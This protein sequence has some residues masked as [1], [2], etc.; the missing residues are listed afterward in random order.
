MHLIGGSFFNRPANLIPEKIL[1]GNSFGLFSPRRHAPRQIFDLI[2]GFSQIAL[3]FNDLQDFRWFRGYLLIPEKGWFKKGFW[4]LIFLKSLVESDSWNSS[5]SVFSEMIFQTDTRAELTM[6]WIFKQTRWAQLPAPHE[7]HFFEIN[8]EYFWRYWKPYK[9]Q[10]LF[11]NYW[12]SFE[13]SK[14]LIKPTFS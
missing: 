9:S 7:I 14:T 13:T 4:F 10:R 5:E 2:I 12:N 3:V 8:L 11:W 6:E 1:I